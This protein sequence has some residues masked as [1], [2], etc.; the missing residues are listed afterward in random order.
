MTAL[1][2]LKTLPVLFVNVDGHEAR[3]ARFREQMDP[4]FREV[5]RVPAVPLGDIVADANDFSI[6]VQHS[7]ANA[8]PN[9]HFARFPSIYTIKEFK[10]PT[11][12]AREYACTRSLVLSTLKA[13][14]MAR[15][16]GYERFM[17]CDDDA[18]PRMQILENM[19]LAPPGDITVWGGAYSSGGLRRD[20]ERFLEGEA[21]RW[22]SVNK[23]P[24][25][26]FS[27]AYEMNTTGADAIEYAIR[28]HF[29]AVDLMW[30]YA[31]ARTTAWT[32]QPSAFTQVGE[33]VR[34][35]KHN[36][37]TREGAT[38]R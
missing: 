30:W 38:T 17:M 2:H 5:I 23:N 6:R 26:F 29:N 31:F 13:V 1:E 3:E 27:Q 10:Q 20:N 32:L 9:G 16:L 14:L 12:R 22:V 24:T 28:N 21:P 15:D 11:K 18:A 4:L 33:S 36:P 35:V 7:R 8:D 25:R 34:V 19:P 37:R